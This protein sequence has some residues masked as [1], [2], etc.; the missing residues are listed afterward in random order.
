MVVR[1]PVSPSLGSAD[2]QSSSAL[3][4][5]ATP[6]SG[7]RLPFQRGA[8]DGRGTANS[9]NPFGED[10]DPKWGSEGYVESNV[11]R[12]PTVLRAG[13][14]RRSAERAREKDDIPASLRIGS[15]TRST[16]SSFDSQRSDAH[17]RR[18]SQ[19]FEWGSP[20]RPA[21]SQQPKSTNPQLRSE[22]TTTSCY[23][24]HEDSSAAA[25]GD[26]PNHLTHSLSVTPPPPHNEQHHNDVPVKMAANLSLSDEPFS[27][28]SNYQVSQSYVQDQHKRDHSPHFYGTPLPSDP[29]AD[30]FD[31]GKIPA[32][33]PSYQAPVIPTSLGIDAVQTPFGDDSE[34][35][36]DSGFSNRNRNSSVGWNPGMDISTFD[37][38]TSRSHGL[39][40]VGE[41][42]EPRPVHRTWDEQKVW[43][44]TER[45]R[46][47][48][49][50]SLAAARAQMEEKERRAEEEYHRGEQEALQEAERAEARAARGDMS[51][52][53]T[54]GS[55]TA[56]VPPLP[57]RDYL[58]ETPELPPR[59]GLDV[60]PDLPPRRPRVSQEEFPMRAQE[61]YIA[62]S[63]KALPTP[64]LSNSALGSETSQA[65]AK[66]QTSE[67][68]HIK[69]I[70]WY[71]SSS[72]GLRQS[73]ILVQNAN[74]PCPLLALVN[75]LVLSTPAGLDTALVETL[76]IREQVSLGLLLDAVFD[77]LMSG[78]RG[79][80]AQEL[81][82]V[83]DLY[84]FLVT[85]H[86]GMNVNPRFIPSPPKALNLMDDSVFD[87]PIQAK[88]SELGGF[89]ETREMRL[90]STFSIPLIHGWLPPS[91][92]PAYAA[93]ERSAKTYEDAQNLQFHE[94]ELE[95]KMRREGL[96]HQEQ[97]LLEDI[98]TIKYFLSQ[99][100]TQLT[101]HGLETMIRCMTAG[102]IAILFR[103]DHFSTLYKHPRSNQLL[104]LVTDMGYSGH[105]EVVWE[106]LVDVNGERCEFF[107]GDFRPVGNVSG[108]A[109]PRSTFSSTSASYNDDD[110]G[111][112]TVATRSRRPQ[113][114]N[115]QKPNF[116]NIGSVIDPSP[117]FH[118]P[119]TSTYDDTIPFQPSPIAE[120]E[121]HDLALALQL[122][123]EEEDRHR[124]EQSRQRHEDEMTAQFLSSQTSSTPEPTS[125][126]RRRGSS[127]TPNRS[128]GQEIRPLI[129]PR[130]DVPL[131]VRNPA[132]PLNTNQPPADAP[133]PTYE[134][135]ASGAPYH[136]PPNHP[137]HP[138]ATPDGA[139]P[140]PGQG[141]QLSAYS[142]NSRIYPQ[143][144]AT[145]VGGPAY[146]GVP[147][148][149]R[150]TNSGRA[151]NLVPDHTV[152]ISPPGHGPRRRQSAGV[153]GEDDK[154]CVVM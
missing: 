124:R 89:E 138:S 59:R 34:K 146:P 26:A 112:T 125:R 82:D 48:N 93:L 86:T 47:E 33:Q 44:R 5:P 87:G 18:G 43:E 108:D 40:G 68:Y 13:E 49:E 92:H 94:E 144:P 81:P 9:D 103:N 147:G 85:L 42:K 15:P 152:G 51:V 148:G 52:Y 69:H 116:A 114:P 115:T 4:Y 31:T 145:P 76:R 95:A 151:G 71:D 131:T 55:E 120:Q 88:S 12:F 27:A 140:G 105:D 77:E 123:E 153:A 100:A 126:G 137:A 36:S 121:D 109:H 17:G 113:N 2:Q 79:G 21:V 50:A 78:R 70:N 57:A 72:T 62:N 111:W 67:T 135:A 7:T 28:S 143:G 29:S 127:N 106:S 39:P 75:A 66:K 84:A 97:R 134:Q 128:R 8:D 132:P 32:S 65:A 10:M 46:R 102:S 19:T 110:N 122:Q 133:P 99:S 24:S 37:A 35:V 23:N 142:Q 136:P 74:G 45:E 154:G 129:P 25:W 141:R 104:T 61:G 3:P 96:D 149:G 41:E 38:H 1:K 139:R 58:D 63:N 14:G 20:E 6:T 118:T 83:G 98:S 119:N 16:R 11:A 91:D 130:R 150:R 30:S 56:A 101:N 64:P 107:A 80:A 53:A 60:G 22:T 117:S 73:P 90:Y 54:V